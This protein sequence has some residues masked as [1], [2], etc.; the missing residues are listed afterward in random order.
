ML[1]VVVAVGGEMF[2]I[3]VTFKVDP[4]LLQQMDTTAQRL[5]ITRSELIRRAVVYYLVAIETD[6][7]LEEAMRVEQ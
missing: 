1:I 2:K 3:I 4:F 5:R 6:K 7:T